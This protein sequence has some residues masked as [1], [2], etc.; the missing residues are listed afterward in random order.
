[1][2]KDAELRKQ[3]P[4]KIPLHYRETPEIFLNQLQGARIIHEKE[5]D[6]EMGSFSNNPIIILSK[7]DTVKL[8]I[9]AQYLKS[10]TDLSNYSWLLEPVQMLK[11]TLDGV[12]YTTSD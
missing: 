6:V 11:T 12:Y 3:Q 9:D 8:V 10:L 4:S 1:M 7:E 5:T 2:K